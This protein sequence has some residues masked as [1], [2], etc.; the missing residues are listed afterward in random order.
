MDMSESEQ[1][2][3]GERR[4]FVMRRQ[5]ITFI[6]LIGMGAFFL[7]HG[8]FPIEG[9]LHIAVFQVSVSLSEGIAFM[10]LGMVGLMMS[11]TT[12]DVSKSIK[13]VVRETAMEQTAEF[14]KITKEQTAEFQ[15]MTKEQTGEFQKI[16]KEQTKDLKET[17]GEQTGAI[18]EMMSVMKEI[19]DT[20]KNMNGTMKDMGGTMKDMGG[21]MTEVKQA[22]QEVKQA[23]QEVKQAVQKQE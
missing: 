16:T 20:M 12:M 8:H 4:R 1:T 14:Q 10:M 19:R 2:M 18:V 22:V 9:L 7:F 23:V 11:W 5:N 15:K 17:I 6:C 3:Q 13:D 21:T